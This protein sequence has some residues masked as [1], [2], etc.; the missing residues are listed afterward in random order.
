MGAG[1]GVRAGASVLGIFLAY[2]AY[3]ADPT[4]AT[5]LRERWAVVHRTLLNK[6]WVDELYDRRWWRRSIA[7]VSGS[8]RFWDEKIVDGAVNGVAYLLEGVSAVLRLLQTGFVGHLRAVHRGRRRGADPPF[9]EA[10]TDG[11]P[12]ALDHRVPPARRGGGDR[13]A[14]AEPAAPDPAPGPRWPRWS[15]WR[16]RCR[17][18]GGSCPARPAGSSPKSTSWLP[19]FG[20]CVRAR[21]ST[22]FRCC[23]C[24]SRWCSRAISVVSAYTAVEK[25]RARVLR[26]PA[27]ARDR[28]A[29]HLPRHR[30]A[31]LLRVLGGD[32]DPDV[33]ADRRSGADRGASTRRSSS[34]STPWSASVLMLVGDPVGSTSSTA[35]AP[36]SPRFDLDAVL[37]AA[38]R[39][40]GPDSGCSSP[41]RSPSRSR[42]RCSRSTPGC[43]TRTSRRRRP[44]R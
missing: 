38:D 31:A 42:C 33:P 10:L 28:H 24:C 23:S 25:R 15:R 36:A 27:G 39:S 12:L 30:P 7:A 19:A 34:S 11:V 14:A 26:L 5:R 1:R 29:R 3:V 6:Y 16:W 20:A 44:A 41:S 9:P 43:P 4:L 18:G 17:S 32:A 8:G 21:A 40:A 13:A 22:A 35:A 37:P 2:R